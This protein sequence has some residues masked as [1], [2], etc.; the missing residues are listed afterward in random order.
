[1]KGFRQQPAGNRKEK[2]R[3]METETKNTAMA[4]R[5]NQMMTQQL[6]QNLKGMHEDIGRALNLI[7]ELQYKILAVQKVAGLDVEAMNAIA[8]EQRLADFTEAS[9]KEDL[10][11]GFTP[12]E[13]VNEQS[14]VIL[15]STTDEGADKGIFRSRIKLSECGVP[16]LINAFMGREVGS[17]AIVTLNG[18]DH[19]VELLAIR[20]P[21]AA[22]ETAESTLSEGDVEDQ[23][24]SPTYETQ[25]QATA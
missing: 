20:Q 18:L 17:K 11:K 9:D 1:M 15:T 21:S 12:G 22:Q 3:S 8:N 14:T 7:S 2:L 25:N 5:I 4:I 13:I 16:D 19:T 23:S 24:T 6:M 10:E